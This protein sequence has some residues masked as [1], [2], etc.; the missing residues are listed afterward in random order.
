MGGLIPG[1]QKQHLLVELD[2]LQDTRLGTI[3]LL[4]PEA[5]CRLV[6]DERY[7]KRTTDDFSS[8][9]DITRE[10]FREAYLKRDVETLK[11]SRL[12]TAIGLVRAAC[13][14]LENRIHDT[15][16][17]EDISID[18]NMWPYKLSST[19]AEE[20]ATAVGIHVGLP[21]VIHAVN[22]PMV[23]LTPVFCRASYTG[24][25]MYHLNDWLGLQAELFKQM[26]LPRVTVV[27]P[28]L[29]HDKELQP[30]DYDSDAD[31]K[32]YKQMS[33]F[34]LTELAFTEWI[35]MELVP[36]EVFSMVRP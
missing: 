11:H 14:A 34:R 33:P 24:M 25:I 18:I 2:A 35:G 4:D 1:D 22:I 12:T 31:L 13:T 16:Y 9:C 32:P 20:I 26:Q 15:P 8:M 7:Y 10:R 19:E 6:L 5:A 27:A 23:E 21:E 36:A 3:A 28:E 17:V 29:F 30:S